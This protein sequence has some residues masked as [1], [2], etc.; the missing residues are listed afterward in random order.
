MTFKTVILGSVNLA[1]R[2]VDALKRTLTKMFSQISRSNVRQQGFEEFVYK[3]HANLQ[4][5]RGWQA[6]HCINWLICRRVPHLKRSCALFTFVRIMSAEKRAI[7]TKTQGKLSNREHAELLSLDGQEL[8][9]RG[10]SRIDQSP[11]KLRAP[12]IT[13]LNN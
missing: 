13:S 3:S 8:F 11:C 2:T 12:L 4:L 9:S 5:A 7:Q 10:R 1:V 6:C